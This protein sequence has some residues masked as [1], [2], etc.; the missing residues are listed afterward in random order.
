MAAEHRHQ[1]AGAE[2]VGA[3]AGRLQRLSVESSLSNVGVLLPGEG[4]SDRCRACRLAARPPA[5][6]ARDDGDEKC[7]KA[8][9][10]VDRDALA[11]HE[12]SLLSP[13]ATVKKRYPEM[14]QR[15]AGADAPSPNGATARSQSPPFVREAKR[16]RDQRQPL[17]LTGLGSGGGALQN[18][19]VVPANRHPRELEEFAVARTELQSAQ[20]VDR[21]IERSRQSL[22]SWRTGEWSR[23][24]TRRA[25]R[26]SPTT[27]LQA[28]S[29]DGCGSIVAAPPN[30][31]LQ[32]TSGEAG[33]HSGSIEFAVRG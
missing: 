14:A 22:R 5:S 4:G 9:A 25:S 19:V 12:F 15:T 23:Q 24:R 32:P 13:A 6:H 33:R 18:P 7:E 20:L 28:R 2:A 21:L 16:R 1:R 10:S 11:R 17:A 27:S 29:L 3:L 26:S 30:T 8:C 31:P